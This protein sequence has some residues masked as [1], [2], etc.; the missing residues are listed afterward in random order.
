MNK[1]NGI[2]EL[3]V[4]QVFDGQNN[5][6]DLIHLAIKVVSQIANLNS[7]ENFTTASAE[8]KEEK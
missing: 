6:T 2:V 8:G 5:S 1:E 7:C 4:K 3:L